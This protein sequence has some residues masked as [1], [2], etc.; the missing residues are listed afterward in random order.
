MPKK[1]KKDVLN[2]DSKNRT[3]FHNVSI[4]KWTITEKA[5]QSCGIR[6]V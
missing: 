2:N 3:W 1:I 6:E 4:I 5:L